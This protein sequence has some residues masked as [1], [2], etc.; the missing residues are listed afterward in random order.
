MPGQS[1]AFAGVMPNAPRQ[2]PSRPTIVRPGIMTANRDWIIGVE[3]HGETVILYPGRKPF[4]LADVENNSADNALVKA[5]RDMIGRRQASVLP[6]EPAYRALLRLLVRPD[7]LR[8]YYTVYPSLETLHLP[9]GRVDV[10]SD[11]E[12]QRAIYPGYYR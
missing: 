2:T 11:D 1:D 10:H 7:G 3:C 9:M 6:G 12:L 4:A 8:A 5:V